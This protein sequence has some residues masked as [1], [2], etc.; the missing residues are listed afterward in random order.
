M[1]IINR[2]EER[3][4]LLFEVEE[5]K[6]YSLWIEERIDDSWIAYAWLEENRLKIVDLSLIIQR[7]K[8]VMKELEVDTGAHLVVEIEFNGTS[9]A[10]GVNKERNIIHLYLPITIDGNGSP[11]IPSRD[12]HE[13]YL[14]YHE[15]MHAKDTL[16]GRI[17]SGG[18]ID[19][20]N[21][22]DIYLSGVATNFSVE[23]RLEKLGKPHR[24][25]TACIGL[26]YSAFI[27]QYVTM[28]GDHSLA[29]KYPREFFESLCEQTW[30]KEINSKEIQS[31][32]RSLTHH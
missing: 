22:F 27:D 9:A 29:E 5:G 32:V 6:S 1:T 20:I 18:L 12:I 8:H 2:K 7:I 26:E 14:L 15:L 31:I 16:E 23:G 13:D 17:P 4:E 19:A 30:G 10:C 11:V 21:D 3:N 28:L 24:S 25:S